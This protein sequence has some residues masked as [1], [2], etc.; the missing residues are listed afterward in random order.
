MECMAAPR[1][2]NEQ[3]PG[4]ICDVPGMPANRNRIRQAGVFTQE[5]HVPGDTYRSNEQEACSYIYCVRHT[6]LWSTE[7]ID[8]YP[9]Q[10]SPFAGSLALERAKDGATFAPK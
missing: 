4:P 1:K 7:Q 5:I 2:S 10:L 6:M 3:H 8:I 9:S